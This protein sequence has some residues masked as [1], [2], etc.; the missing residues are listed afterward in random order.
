MTA[1]DTTSLVDALRSRV[2]GSVVAPGDADWDVARQAWNLAADQHPAAVALPESVD[3]VVAV[4]EV[5]RAHGLRVAPQGTGHNATP[6]GDL[7]DTILLKTGALN[8]VEID[9]EGRRARVGAG[10]VWAELTAPA[11]EHG[12]APLA[13]S[14]PNVGIAGYAVGGGLSWLGRKFGSCAESV[15][16]FE[17]VTADGRVVRADAEHETD[18]FWAL[19]GGGGSFGIVTAVELR[20]F[21]VGDVYAGMM[22]WPAERASEVMHAWREWTLTA[23]EEVTTS[24]RLLSVPDDP[25]IPEP[26]RGGAFAVI[27]GAFVG[28][29][30]AGREVLAPLRALEPAM[31][32]W[33]TMPPAGLSYVHMD[34]EDPM[35]G[36]SDSVM[37]TELTAEAVDRIVEL[38]GPGSGSP[39]MMAEVR[40]LGGALSREREGHGARGA[41]DGDYVVFN[42]GL[43]LSPEVTEAT[44]AAARALNAA[45][46]EWHA[47]S[48]YLNF[49]EQGV[50]PAGFYRPEA[51]ARLRA[52]KAAVD[53]D[54]VIRSNHPI[55]PAE[56]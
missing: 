23:P 52:I 29:E 51:Y 20:L 22:L 10:V 30:A 47:P 16:A 27:D 50:D 41:F 17:L 24:F 39:L 19:R 34:P 1:I 55:P 6:F 25:S 46:A 9:V 5:A 35:P 13:G 37:L 42:G 44:L 8:Q 45:L 38:A 56:G 4:V 31:D 18:L 53:P 26:L 15:L 43:A 3:D 36:V 14:S 28:D 48:S 11:S 7:G 49:V 40:H 12:L 32:G 33:T 21:E 2:T 54:D